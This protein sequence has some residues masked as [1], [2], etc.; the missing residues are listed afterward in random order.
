M[1]TYLLF[2]VG[3][4]LLIYGA[5]WLVDGAASIAKKFRISNIVIGLTIVAFGTSSPEL[6]VNIIA[7]FDGNADVAMGNIMGS[8]ISNILLILGVSAIIFPL[9]VNRNTYLKET[10]LSLLAAILLGIC[11]NDMIIDAFPNSVLSRS[12]GMIFIGFF[13]LFMY[14]AFSIA[15]Q[16]DPETMDEIVEMPVWK[17]ITLIIVGIGGLVIGGKWIVNGAVDIAARLGMS[18]ALISLTIVAVGTSLP[19]L[20]TC[21]VAALKKNSDIVI[22]NVIGSNIFNVFFVLGVSAVIKPLPFNESLNFDVL[23][24][25]G[26]ALLLLVFLALPR[27]RVLERWQGITLLSLYI[28]Y[29]IYLINRG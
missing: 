19:E 13:I 8:N 3:F 20:A 24:G 15:S 22:G 25:I 7:S 23:V 16:S 26:S 5:N 14:Y 28:A 10:P 9:S 17:S 6:V 12:D 1:L 18:Q 4:V 11:A 27:K 29:T 2:V 21:V